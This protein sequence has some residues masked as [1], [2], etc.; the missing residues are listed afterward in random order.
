[1]DSFYRSLSGEAIEKCARG[2]Y[3]FD[4]PDAFDFTL[5]LETLNKLKN[6][7]CVEIPIY[8]FKTHKRLVHNLSFAPI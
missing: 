6:G 1:M 4:H 7:K 5:L 3:N 2:E 8:D